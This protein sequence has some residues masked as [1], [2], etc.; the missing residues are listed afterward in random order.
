[1]VPLGD[2]AKV[3]EVKAPVQVTHVDGARTAS[4]TATSVDNNI[5][6]AS[7]AVNKALDGR[8]AARTAPPGSWAAPRR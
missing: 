1:M 2:I 7:T 5:G 6:A 8:E 3:V 4:I